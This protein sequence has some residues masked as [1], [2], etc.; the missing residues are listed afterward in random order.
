MT[1]P[2]KTPPANPVPFEPE[3]SQRE[4]KELLEKNLALTAEIHEMTHKIKRYITFQK[5]LSFIYFLL[6]VV[7]LVLSAIYLP[8]LI[9]N[10]VGQYGDLI[11]VP[12]GKLDVGSLLQGK[13]QPSQQ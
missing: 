1:I 8:P 12:A 5:V 4:L 9:K 2:L 10:M 13:I 3:V 11:G 7:P 6:I